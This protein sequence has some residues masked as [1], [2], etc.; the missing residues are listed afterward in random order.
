MKQINSTHMDDYKNKAEPPPE[1]DM[2]EASELRDHCEK[3]KI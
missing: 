2:Y 1:H 3:K